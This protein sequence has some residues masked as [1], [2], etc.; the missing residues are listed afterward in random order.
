MSNST[1]V[2]AWKNEDGCL[3]SPVGA[4]EL[5]DAELE[6][7]DGMGGRGGSR[8]GNFS[9]VAISCKSLSFACLV[10][11]VNVSNID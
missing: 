6:I 2:R 1:L 4:I 8:C 9:I 7:V 3:E 5:T 10:T 11:F